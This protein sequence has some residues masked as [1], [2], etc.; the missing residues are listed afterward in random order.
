VV[1]TIP[2]VQWVNR[3]SYS[4]LSC[5]LESLFGRLETMFHLGLRFSNVALDCRSLVNVALIPLVPPCV[6]VSASCT[7]TAFA[8]K[9]DS[10]R[11]SEV[12]KI[13]I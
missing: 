13:D 2:S 4:A 11:E 7:R 12:G 6:T 8:Y 10:Q 1:G 3:C 5:N 9:E